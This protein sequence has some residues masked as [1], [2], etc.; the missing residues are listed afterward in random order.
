VGL[1]MGMG[2][3]RALGRKIENIQKVDCI[4]S[5]DS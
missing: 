5:I 3:G 1:E 2:L 4:D